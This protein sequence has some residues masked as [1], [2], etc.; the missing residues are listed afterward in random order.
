[1]A[2]LLEQ[3]IQRSTLLT[4]NPATEKEVQDA[5]A[6]PDY[7]GRSVLSAITIDFQGLPEDNLMAIC[8]YLEGIEPGDVQPLEWRGLLKDIKSRG[9]LKISPRVYIPRDKVPVLQL[10]YDTWLSWFRG[11]R[12]QLSGSDNGIIDHG[13]SDTS[14]Q[15][16]TSIGR[17]LEQLGSQYLPLARG[18]IYSHVLEAANTFSS[19]TEAEQNHPE[20]ISELLN[21]TYQSVVSFPELVCQDWS[22]LACVSIEQGVS[23]LDVLLDIPIVVEYKGAQYLLGVLSFGNRIVCFDDTYSGNRY[24][25]SFPSLDDITDV[26]YNSPLT[27]GGTH[28][29]MKMWYRLKFLLLHK[30]GLWISHWGCGRIDR[31]YNSNSVRVGMDC[32]GG[33]EIDTKIYEYCES[34]PVV[35]ED[36]VGEL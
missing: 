29:R 22:D 5:I 26:Y 36:P 30:A 16:D 24:S 21:L 31:T 3:A 34:N 7:F 13:S 25:V 18:L 10:S 11:Y 4:G 1:M 19:F 9:L 33:H 27:S 14:L 20:L 6:Y 2:T 15:Y 35:N 8:K 28:Y 12:Y 17:G 32:L 23:R